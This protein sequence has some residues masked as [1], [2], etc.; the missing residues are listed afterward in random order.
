MG[1]PHPDYLLDELTSGQLAEWVA[2]D[3]VEHIDGNF[4]L[5]LQLASIHADLLNLAQSIY[6]SKGKKLKCSAADFMPFGKWEGEPVKKQSIEE[7]KNILLAIAGKA[8]KK[9]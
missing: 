6:G 8:G 4:K 9:P 7:M 1:Y 2:Y 3:S 5:E